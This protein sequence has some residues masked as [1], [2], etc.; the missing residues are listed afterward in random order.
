MIFVG[1]GLSLNQG[2]PS[3]KDLVLETLESKKDYILKADDYSNALSAGI[4]DPIDI[5]NK[6]EPS[7]KHIFEI[8][9][10]I[11]KSK[12]KESP[13][14]KKLDKITTK[15]ITTNFD[16]LIEDNS[17]IDNVVS[18]QGAYQYSQLNSK[19][20]YIIKMHGD[21]N[22]I[23][24]CVI[25]ESQYKSLY[26]GE[27]LSTFQLK[28]ILSNH[29]V[30]FMGFSFQDP[31]V[32]E[33][34]EHIH[35]LYD[36]YGQDHYL[37]STN[38]WPPTESVKT[39]N[40][41]SYDELDIF[42]DLLIEIKNPKAIQSNIS[43]E[44]EEYPYDDEV[45]LTRDIDG[46]DIPP[47][48]NNWVG[49]EKELKLLRNKHFKVIAITGM[50]GEGKSALAS[51]YLT[52][53]DHIEA[54]E[55]LEWR[56]FKEEDH[57]FQHKLHTMIRSIDPSITI[58]SMAGCSDDQL[59]SLFFR[60]LGNKKSIFIL[61][62][63]DSYIDL[64]D[65]K[66]TKGMGKLIQ[67]ALSCDHKSQFIFTCRPFISFADVDFMQIPLSGLDINTTIN[68]FTL[69][70]LNLNE[71]RII[72]HATRS[73]KLTKGH[74][75][76][77]SLIIAQARRG[78]KFISEFLDQIELGDNINVSDSSILSEKIL[79]NI[80]NSLLDRDKLVLRTL[81]ESVRP[82]TA[83][84]YAEILTPELTFNKF[85]KTIKALKNLNLIIEK[86]NT[87]FIELHP[88]VKEFIKKNYQISDR[89]KY[90]SLLIKHYD[91]YIVVLKNAISYKLNFDEFSNFTNKAE[92]SVTA[93]DFQNAI[94]TLLEVHGAM[95]A[96][97]YI[98]EFLRVAN[99]LFSRISWSKRSV[100][101]LNNFEKLLEWTVKSSVE[102]GAEDINK[103]L[104]EKF[105]SIIEHKEESYIRLCAIKAY[106]FWFKGEHTDCLS[107][108][109]EA[110]FLLKKGNQPDN[111]SIEHHRALSLRDSETLPNI[112]EALK[113]FLGQYK[114]ESL[115]DPQ[116]DSNNP[117]G[118]V[119][120]NV[121]KCL[122][123]KGQT[124]EAI[125]CF[126]KAFVYIENSDT[127]D[128]LL[129]LGYASFWIAEALESNNLKEEALYFF[130]YALDSWK[131]CSP[132]L[133]N[134]NSNRILNY[135][136]SNSNYQSILSQE[137]WRVE[138][139]CNSWVQNHFNKL[140]ETDNNK[141]PTH[142]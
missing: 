40:I 115:L 139:F 55:Y 102:F 142:I 28:K 46:G 47:H 33:L 126:C 109:D 96:G 138:K 18:T 1:A 62:N 78:E 107:I 23:E 75:L 128:R 10:K 4:M 129:N 134:R 6:I 120:G 113:Y 125:H 98:E 24:N 131:S 101:K 42:L 69:A 72:I 89:N 90:I 59:I 36:S 64:E 87:S 88:L 8:F 110:L 100:S 52:N 13:K 140:N 130:K 37:I 133:S 2:F 86:K 77:L 54:Y 50:G 112:N 11:L 105:S 81:A 30:L 22:D 27:K 66:P 74:A 127:G 83:D 41:S 137:L 118:I 43:K 119:F 68:F 135:S 82:E 51:H 17:E 14:H 104:I 99:I 48:V 61:D 136:K 35:T 65:F 103:N 25:F 70:K 114:L 67:K 80:W 92:L 16:S 106:S 121:G 32:K 141:T 5:L 15:F 108:S 63:I 31:Y 49:R 39:I 26:E 58:N 60:T 124:N 44:N 132:V 84:D 79:S 12:P 71:D 97:G 73:Q 116:D 29:T 21:I 57:T 111:Y 19:D 20:S 95:S 76:W 123:L 34:F 93:G 91:K 45:I 9:E 3:W 85:S 38:D 122:L 56:D 53:T 117:N 7:K 94:N